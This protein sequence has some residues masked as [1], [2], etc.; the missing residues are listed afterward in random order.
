MDNV[1]TC[2]VKSKNIPN[3][4]VFVSCLLINCCQIL[5]IDLVLDGFNCGRLK[6]DF[7]EALL[8]LC[9]GIIL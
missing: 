9:A 8:F 7:L 1:T 4:N 2:E 5:K 3:Q 6:C